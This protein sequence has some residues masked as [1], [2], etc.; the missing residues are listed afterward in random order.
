MSARMFPKPSLL[1]A[2]ALRESQAHRL[3]RGWVS[4]LAGLARSLPLQRGCASADLIKLPGWG[5]A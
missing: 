1:L 4:S 5:R 3:Q 2:E